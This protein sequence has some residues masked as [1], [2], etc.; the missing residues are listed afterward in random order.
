M[1]QFMK[2]DD[3]GEWASLPVAVFYT[4]D[5][6]ELH[7]YIEFPAIYHKDPIR[8]HMSA[9]RPGESADQARKRSADEFL[10]LQN[11][12]FFDIW[13][14]AGVDEIL[15]ALREKVTGVVRG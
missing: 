9:P 5:F 2:K 11:S 3:R 10:A 13:A 6:Q 4:K 12:P 14:S 7:R 15:S 1:A 8:A